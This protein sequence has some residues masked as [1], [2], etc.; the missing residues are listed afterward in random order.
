MSDTCIGVNYAAA[1]PGI[2]TKIPG[3]TK[4]LIEKQGHNWLRM[5]CTATS[6][7]AQLVS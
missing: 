1:L 2:G 3:I 4:K 6:H 7:I 5:R